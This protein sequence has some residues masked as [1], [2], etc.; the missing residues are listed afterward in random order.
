VEP[1]LTTFRKGRK[2]SGEP[3]LT[4]FRKGRKRSGEPNLTTFRKGRKRS[5][6]PNPL[7]KS[8]AKLTNP[9]SKIETYLYLIC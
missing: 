1:N 2:R 7:L 6:E 9:L 4:T 3:N 5:G 8:G